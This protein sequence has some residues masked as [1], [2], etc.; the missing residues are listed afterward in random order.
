MKRREFLT[1]AAI[2]GSAIVL[3]PIAACTRETNNKQAEI[4]T[5]EFK[6]DAE[7]DEKTVNDLQQ[8]MKNGEISSEELVQKYLDRIHE[9][10]KQGPKLRSVIEIN[11]EAHSIARKMDQERN[12]GK[13]RG[14]LHGI[15]IIV[16]DN[17]DTGDQMQTTAGSL[18]LE[19]FNAQEDAFI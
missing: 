2:G 10:D 7:L 11:P 9:I 18:A 12:S 6:K 13:V 16:K 14:P 5:S 8:M 3:N 4:A 17:I 19:G 15:P 1:S